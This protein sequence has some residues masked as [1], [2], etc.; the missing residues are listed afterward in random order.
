MDHVF[1]RH[2][3]ASDGMHRM[4]MGTFCEDALETMLE[5]LKARGAG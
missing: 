5:W 4:G 1:G 3:S 2:A